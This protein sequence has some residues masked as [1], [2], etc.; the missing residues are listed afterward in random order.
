[1]PGLVSLLAVVLAAQAPVV[2]GPTRSGVRM[3]AFDRH[4]ALCT[5]LRG[6][7]QYGRPDCGRPALTLRRFPLSI[8][9]NRRRSIGEGLVAPEVAAVELVFRHGR[10]VRAE[11][12]AGEDYDG[13]YAGKLRFF[14]AEWRGLGRGSFEGPLFA[15]LLGSQGELLAVI[16]MSYEGVRVT[17]RTTVA[18]GR[19]GRAPW[20]LVAYKRRVLASLP[21]NEERF[22]DTTC[23]GLV[24]N[25]GRR[26]LGGAR[27]EDCRR[28]DHPERVLDFNSDQ[29][30]EPVGNATVGFAAD[31]TRRLV[32]VLGDGRRRRVPI[33]R[34]PRRL[35]GE[36]AFALALDRRTA[37][38]RLVAIDVRG[39]HR[40]LAAG[41]APGMTDCPSN[42]G[43]FVLLTY[44]F[45]PPREPTGAVAF[46][47]ED[48]GALICP[49]LV[50]PPRASDCID[51]PLD[52]YEGVVL[53]HAAGSATAVAGVMPA[54]V[55]ALVLELD[56]GDKVR[57]ATS[58]SG[59]YAGQYAGKLRFFSAL[60]PGH[61]RVEE[62]RPIDDHGR[63]L[64][65]RPGPDFQPVDRPYQV[66]M[67]LGGGYRLGATTFTYDDKRWPCLQIA[68]GPFSTSFFD[69]SGFDFLDVRVEVPCRPRETLLWGRLPRRA[70][71]VYAETSAGRFAGRVVSLR[72]RLHVAANAF[73]LVLPAPARPTAL[74]FPGARRPR[75]SL[76][77]PSAAEQCG[78]SDSLP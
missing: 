20:S 73:A 71:A 12:S 9:S 40:V 61:R 65:E 11:T 2:A 46:Q 58:F 78:W 8:D 38:R 15:R 41:V 53:S 37:V 59:P 34:L 27:V 52:D 68:R 35:G 69:C 60:L 29:G 32:A 10:R 55:A 5:Q 13:R 50:G 14:L 56:G 43:V 3:V 36:R 22:A 44:G 63:R 24:D 39:H 48:R 74:V 57:L 19:V 7:D 31:T 4:G 67:R 21:G 54:Y 72:R 1:V 16:D 76:R 70:H 23:V 26:F 30:C 18:R 42:G 75:M 6:P 77:M 17:P 64:P 66:L 45:E 28:A 51:P 47:V 33:V 62:V 49:S 25:S